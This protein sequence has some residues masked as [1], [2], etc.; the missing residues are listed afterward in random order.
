M[1]WGPNGDQN[2]PLTLKNGDLWLLK[3]QNVAVFLSV[4]FFTDCKGILMY[5][6]PNADKFGQLKTKNE[7]L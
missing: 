6:G 2:G 5:C 3:L 4:F 1:Q 7:A